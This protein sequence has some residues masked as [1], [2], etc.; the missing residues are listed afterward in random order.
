[1]KNDVVLFDQG[2]ADEML[3]EHVAGK[4]DHAKKLFTLLVIAEWSTLNSKR[5]GGVS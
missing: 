2:I 5:I 3:D 4:A 1:M